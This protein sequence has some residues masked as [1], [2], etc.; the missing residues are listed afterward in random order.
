VTKRES[1]K[2]NKSNLFGGKEKAKK[3]TR[4][5]ASYLTNAKDSLSFNKSLSPDKPIMNLKLKDDKQAK[6][7]GF[8]VFEAE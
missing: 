4:T 1:Y 3:S 5:R 2:Q 8:H 6:K 7:D